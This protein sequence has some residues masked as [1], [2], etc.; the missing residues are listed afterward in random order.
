MIITSAC[1]AAH[2][3]LHSAEEKSKMI[4]IGLRRGAT[5]HEIMNAKFSYAHDG[6][7]TFCFIYNAVDVITRVGVAKRNIKDRPD[8]K[9][10]RWVSFSSAMKGGEGYL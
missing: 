2:F 3:M 1:L 4:K 10:G 7:F 6:N 5:A 9:I 8:H